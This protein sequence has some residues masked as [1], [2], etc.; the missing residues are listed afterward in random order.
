M[1]IRALRFE[2]KWISR[3]DLLAGLLSLWGASGFLYLVQA[4]LAYRR[5][6]ADA[7]TSLAALTGINAALRLDAEELTTQAYLDEL[8][9]ALNRHGLRDL[10]T[11]QIRVPHLLG[12]P[13]A[14]LLADLDHFKLV[15]DKYGHLEGDAVLR[16]FVQ[17]VQA[18]LRG[19]DRLVRW[20]GEE[21]LIV[22]P[23]TTA[24]QA[25]VLAEA[26]RAAVAAHRWADGK[27]LTVSCGVAALTEVDDF[28][29]ALAR[30]DAA[31]YRAKQSGRNCVA[32]ERGPVLPEPA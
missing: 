11:R 22:C 9:G 13:C 25:L 23:G 15:N 16:E 26:V 31:L 12:L 4:L 2:G 18:Q 19:T 27:T 28:S 5:R 8:T 6:L 29:A 20:G 21:F 14:L 1:A 17:L 24:E 10:L 7:R 30:A 3:G 32:F